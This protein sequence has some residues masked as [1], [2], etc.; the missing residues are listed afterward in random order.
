MHTCLQVA[1]AQ[2]GTLTVVPGVMQSPLPQEIRVAWLSSRQAEQTLKA[3]ASI[4]K[5]QVLFFA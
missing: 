1:R 3:P 5:L 2:G 4:K